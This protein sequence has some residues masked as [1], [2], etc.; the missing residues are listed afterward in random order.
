MLPQGRGSSRIWS[1]DL[2]QNNPDECLCQSRKMR[3]AVGDEG[4]GL[5]SDRRYSQNGKVQQLTIKTVKKDLQLVLGMALCSRAH[6]GVKRLQSRQDGDKANCGACPLNTQD[7][8]QKHAFDA[9]RSEILWGRLVHR[10]DRD[11]SNPRT[12]LRSPCREQILY[13]IMPPP[14]SSQK[15]GRGISSISCRVPNKVVRKNA[16]TLF[17]STHITCRCSRE[18][19]LWADGNRLPQ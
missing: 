10:G 2:R 15:G 14:T 17:C 5:E 1:V 18:E 8:T 9:N 3:V 13:R 12:S 7:L 6:C 4:K 11:I 19:I 16:S